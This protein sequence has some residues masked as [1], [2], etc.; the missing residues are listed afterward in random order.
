MDYLIDII[1]KIACFYVFAS[2]ILNL[3]NDERYKKYINMFTGLI[4][5]ILIMKPVINM[6]SS[7]NHF[8]TLLKTNEAD[9]MSREMAD[10]ISVAGNQGRELILNEF[11]EALKSSL[12]D[13]FL[14]YGITLENAEAE[15]E[16]DRTDSDYGRITS[17]QITAKGFDDNNSYSVAVTELKKYISNVYKIN[18]N[19]IHIN[20]TC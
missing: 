9:N 15:V 3:V 5:I 6:F 13:K 11:N 2:F 14:E 1:K 17:L 20:I 18:K 19:N 10:K 16:F 8:E 7:E 12:S 4:M